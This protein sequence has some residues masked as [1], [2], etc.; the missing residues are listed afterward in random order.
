[1]KPFKAILLL[2]ALLSAGTLMAQQDASQAPA[3]ATPP[4]TQQH[5]PNPNRQAKHLAKELGLTRDQVAQIEPILADRS[6]QME[7]IRADTSLT[8]QDRHAKTRALQ[9]DSKAKIEAVLNDA[10]KQQYEQ[11]LA[12]RRS[13]RSQESAPAPQG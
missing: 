8:P 4:T 10:Q 9:Q 7:S 11:M 2:G 6:Q 5:A 12:Q 3:P 13:R 1:M